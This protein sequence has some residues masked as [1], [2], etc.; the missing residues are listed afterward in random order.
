MDFLEIVSSAKAI[1]RFDLDACVLQ[2]LKHTLTTGFPGDFVAC[3]NF[4]DDVVNSLAEL[5]LLFNGPA[6]EEIMQVW[7]LR[8]I[9]REYD[10]CTIS[11][12]T[13]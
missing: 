4:F 11:I 12:L 2:D 10:D 9:A 5:G 8:S 13:L 6:V 7:G 1:G 3:K